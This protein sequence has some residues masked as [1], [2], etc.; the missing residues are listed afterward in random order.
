MNILGRRWRTS[1]QPLATRLLFW[2]FIRI[3][4]VWI[5][6]GIVGYDVEDP[7]EHYS[8]KKNGPDNLFIFL[9]ILWKYDEWKKTRVFPCAALSGCFL[10]RLIV[11][12]IHFLVNELQECNPID[13]MSQRLISFFVK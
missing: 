12:W 3:Y 4:R 2:H 7:P 9:I 11:T 5:W 6:I 1:D 8:A 13:S 10:A